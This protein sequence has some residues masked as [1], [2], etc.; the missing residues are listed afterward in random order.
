MSLIIAFSIFSLIFFG[1]KI[2]NHTKNNRK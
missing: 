1:F 2:H